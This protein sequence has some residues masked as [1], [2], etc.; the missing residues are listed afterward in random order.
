MFQMHSKVIQ[1]Y[2]YIYS[3]NILF[4]SSHFYSCLI[5]DFFP[6][7]SVVMNPPAKQGDAGSIPESGRSPGEGNGNQL[8]YSYLGN[9]MDWQAIVHGVV[10]ESDMT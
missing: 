6:G 5:R 4:Y 10:R 3:I 1:L 9:P 2:I 7:G 8:K